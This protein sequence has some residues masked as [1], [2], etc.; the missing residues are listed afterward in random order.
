MTASPAAQQAVAVV[1]GASGGIGRAIAVELAASCSHLVLHFCSRRDEIGETEQAVTAAGAETRIVQA[2]LSSPA[3]R[4]RL[5][6]AAWDW[7]GRID[8]YIHAA[9]AD[10]LTGPA[11][12]WTFDEKLDRLWQVD[13]RGTVDCCREVGR[14]MAAMAGESRPTIVTIGW[15]QA[16]QGME[17]DSGEMF[18]AVKGAVAAFTRSLAQTLAPQVRVNCVSP[19]WIQTAWGA[20][21][22]DVWHRRASKQSLSRRWGTAADVAR[23]VAFV[24]SPQA[25][26]VNGQVLHVNGGFCYYPEDGT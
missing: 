21:A 24:A 11:R 2:D 5:V 3:E 7:Q 4:K 16:D 13:V 6:D 23:V 25:A 8:R 9:G 18:A 22:E 26:F 20:T 12:D 15:D 10:V 1:T 19:G 14:R 17:G